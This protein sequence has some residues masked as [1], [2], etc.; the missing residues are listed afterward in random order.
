MGVQGLWKLLR[1]VGQRVPVATLSRRRLAVDVSI[2]L[3]QFVKA[4]RDTEGNML[5]NAHLLGMLRRICKLLFH[6]IRPVFVFDGPAPMLKRRTLQQRARI[7]RK[8]RSSL[9]RAAERLLINQLKMQSL[10][11]ARLALERKGKAGAEQTGGAAAAG[12]KREALGSGSEAPGTGQVHSRGNGGMGRA[13][14]ER[15]SGW[16]CKVCTYASNPLGSAI[17]TICAVGERPENEAVDVRAGSGEKGEKEEEEEKDDEDLSH[18]PRDSLATADAEVVAALP[19]SMQYNVMRDRVVR[20]RA[21]DA[22]AFRR[23]RSSAG[24]FSKFQL[25]S[26]LKNSRFNQRV[27]SAREKA[28]TAHSSSGD[29][30]SVGRSYTYIQNSRMG[31]PGPP[32]PGKLRPGRPES[33]APKPLTRRQRLSMPAVAPRRNPLIHRDMAYDKVFQSLVDGQ[34]LVSHKLKMSPEASSSVKSNGGKVD[35]GTEDLG[36]ADP[37]TVSPLQPLQSVALEGEQGYIDDFLDDSD[38]T[39]AD[40]ANISHA[41][42]Q[43]KPAQPIVNAAT[44][45]AS[46]PPVQRADVISLLD[47]ESSDEVEGISSVEITSQQPVARAGKGWTCSNCGSFNSLAT[48][49]K[50]WQQRYCGTCRAARSTRTASPTVVESPPKTSGKRGNASAP[51]W[52]CGRCTFANSPTDVACAVCA[53]PRQGKALELPVRKPASSDVGK[54]S[55]PKTRLAPASTSIADK[56]GILTRSAPEP[57]HDSPPAKPADP[58]PFTT[59]GKAQANTQGGSGRGESEGA[60]PA[61]RP[62]CSISSGTAEE[63]KKDAPFCVGDSGPVAPV[64]KPT[65]ALESQASSTKSTAAEPQRPLQPRTASV[66]TVFQVL[67][68]GKSGGGGGGNDNVWCDLDECTLREDGKYDVRVSRE[69]AAAQQAGIAGL[70]AVG[71]EA[72]FVRRLNRQSKDD[73]EFDALLR[74][75]EES[76]DRAPTPPPSPPVQGEASNGPIPSDEAARR[77]LQEQEGALYAEAKK[78]DRARRAQ[79]SVAAQ[80]TPQMLEDAKL[81]LRIFGIPYVV[82]PAEAEAQCAQLAAAGLVDGVLTE[83]SDTFL[84]AEEIAVYKNVFDEKQ[85]VERYQSRDIK[86]ELGLTR[87]HLIRVALLV[88][89]DYTQGV[90]GV[91]I[92][93]ALEILAAFPGADGLGD[94]RKWIYSNEPAVRPAAEPPSGA[95]IL[96]HRRALFK[97]KHRNIRGSWEV[98]AGFPDPSIVGAY[99]HPTIDDSTTPFSWG[100]PEFGLLFS[101]CRDRFG[102]DADRTQRE[103]GPVQKAVSSATT[104]SRLDSFYTPTGRFARHASKRLA[105]SVA[106]LTEIAEVTTATGRAPAAIATAAAANPALDGSSDLNVVG[107]RGKSRTGVA[108]R[109]QSDVASESQ[110]G[111]AAENSLPMGTVVESQ[112]VRGCVLTTFTEPGSKAQYVRIQFDTGVAMTLLSSEIRVVAKP[113][114]PDPSGL[115]AKQIRAQLR[116]R[117]L[118]T[119]GL[120]AELVERF[121]CAMGRE[122]AALAS[123]A[124]NSQSV[125]FPGARAAAGSSN[126]ESSGAQTASPTDEVLAGLAKIQNK[127]LRNRLRKALKRKIGAGPAGSGPSQPPKPKRKKRTRGE[128]AVAPPESEPRVVIPDESVLGAVTVTTNRAPVM[129][130]WA[131]VVA[132]RIGFKYAEALSLGRAVTYLNAQSKGHSLGLLSEQDTSKVPAD[133]PNFLTVG[134]L[135]RPVP[136]L[137]TPQ[138]VRGLTL[139][140][141][142]VPPATVHRYL[143]HAFSHHFLAARTAMQLAVR[144]YPV[145]RLKENL[146]RVAYTVYTAF[147]PQIAD[148][149]AGW[150]A[151]GTLSCAT[152]LSQRVSKP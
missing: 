119:T 42:N 93:N 106:Q 75:E 25:S 52:V 86:R 128:I 11:S 19:M 78:I 22:L 32:R 6:R 83:D 152:V 20:R 31:A 136:A 88:G 15:T 1:P 45:P 147:R 46:L 103:L 116:L 65:G 95:G 64:T 99:L 55:Q 4:M 150:G 23:A 145:Q 127:E 29:P 133:L 123:Q 67:V 114:G 122:A 96:E 40:D 85:Y 73:A 37:G 58:Q 146:G 26:F 117:G 71:V 24:S 54:S 149:R 120:K 35:P 131:T 13:S 130:L 9:A 137:R 60:E 70:S 39:S 47:D 134:L 132:E 5:R 144:S 142:A 148:G 43:A 143:E 125:P 84:F 12:G 49:F 14:G 17:C 118:S 38:S 3:T 82:S 59:T 110:S 7:K 121:A 61:L 41:A 63:S 115:S 126:P 98:P 76:M 80:V 100:Q 27:K 56:P 97:Y 51:K 50:L 62:Q 111:T 33:R 44:A 69:S 112:G 81:L 10:A 36:T 77:A 141:A 113:Q 140:G 72:M 139:K 108:S 68:E 34:S 101:F 94:F 151:K 104:Q 79:E 90:H 74:Q 8:A 57:V 91:G 109:S 87:A 18:I 138:G 53:T 28:A 105:R 92:V 129:T 30:S 135:G 16:V 48:K 124:T 107:G 21:L 102:W 89:S 2:W 66:G